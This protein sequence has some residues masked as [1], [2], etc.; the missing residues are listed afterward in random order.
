MLLLLLLTA[1]SAVSAAPQAD[2]QCDV[3]SELQN[4]ECLAERAERYDTELA[5]YVFAARQR[6]EHEGRESAADTASARRALERFSEAEAAW[7]KYQ[8]AECAAIY[9]H[10]S[11]GSIRNSAALRC[12]IALTRSHT[13]TVWADWLTYFDDTPPI[14]PEPPATALP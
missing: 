10:L 3:G 12:R 14:Q 4:N 6:L 8:D 11:D 9:E 2:P 5:S 13:H 1:T 7:S